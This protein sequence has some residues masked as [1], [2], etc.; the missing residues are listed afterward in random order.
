MIK[1]K[2]KIF[3]VQ[4]VIFL[5]ASIIVYFFYFTDR[6]NKVNRDQTDE[7]TVGLSNN[8]DE[9][10]NIFNDIEY[11]GFD[12]SGNRYYLFSKEAIFDNERPEIVNMR[13][14]F[15]K[16]TFKDDT[17]LTIR[18]DKGVYNNKTLDMLFREN[19]RSDYEKHI[20]YSQKIDYFNEESK[21]N[22]YG[23]I[24]GEGPK[25]KILAENLN[26]D[27]KNKTLDI[28]AIENNQVNVN[29]KK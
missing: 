11:S 14:V 1:R 22:I 9:K 26:F 2:K 27:L 4:F 6:E 10:A 29:L 25:G 8:E 18:A 17:V 21:L 23:K 28:S 19:I 16:F 13:G 24:S 15:A 12:F 20:L 7:K 3:L 5:I